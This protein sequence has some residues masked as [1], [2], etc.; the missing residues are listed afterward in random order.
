MKTIHLVLLASFF[1]VPTLVSAHQPRLVESAA[2]EV[3]DPEVSKA[4]YGELS[5]AP[6]IYTI[7]TP[8]PFALYVGILMPYA[9]NSTKD[10]LVEIRKD[11]ELVQV[12]GGKGADWK[13]MF[14]F[15][16][17]S[18][19]WDGGEYKANAGAGEYTVSVSSTNNNSK[20]SLAIG[21]IE[22]FNVSE[23]IS[24]INLIP[25]LKNNFFNESTISFIK[26]PF[27][28]GYI[29]IMYI[30]AF[31]FGFLYRF[32]LKK[33]AKGSVRGVQKNIAKKDRLIRLI[34][35]IGLL[36][37]AITTTWSPWLLFFSG[38]ALFETIFSWCGFYAAIGR[39]TCPVE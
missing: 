29:L 14:E 6:H 16:G 9:E 39:N 19:Y 4:Y 34:I 25:Q 37:W 17:Q 11:K 38:F 12:I 18:S 10:V 8:S 22:A 21:E 35:A 26:S 28:W 31:V 32:V 24:A 27:G 23:T 7:S 15:F 3:T 33:F 30:L 13:K 2:I 1:L 36:V 20:Y 5:G